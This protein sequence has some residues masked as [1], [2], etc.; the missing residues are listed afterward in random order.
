MRR[1]LAHPMLA[2]IF[3]KVYQTFTRFAPFIPDEKCTQVLRQAVEKSEAIERE[4]RKA[5]IQNVEKGSL[6][7][8]FFFSALNAAFGTLQSSTKAVESKVLQSMI[9][10]C[11]SARHDATTRRRVE[12]LAKDNATKYPEWVLNSKSRGVPRPKLSA[13]AKQTLEK[14]YMDHY[15]EPFPTFAEKLELAQV[16]NITIK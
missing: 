7:V 9:S 8:N 12:S 10:A 6:N 16:C 5:G 11:S 13:F 2:V 3:K 15:D 1:I 4:S 14:Y